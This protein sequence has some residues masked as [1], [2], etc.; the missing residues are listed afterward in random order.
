MFIRNALRESSSLGNPFEN[1]DTFYFIFC[2]KRTIAT[3][4]C[5]IK[6]SKNKQKSYHLV[7]EKN[8]N[9]KNLYTRK[10]LLFK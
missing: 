5:N 7:P 2:L 4:M 6:I 9:K 8:L 1:T 10:K 3:A